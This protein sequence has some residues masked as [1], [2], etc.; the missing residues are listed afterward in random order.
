MLPTE[1]QARVRPS[2]MKSTAVVVVRGRWRGAEGSVDNM[3]ETRQRRRDATDEGNELSSILV[4]AEHE[5]NRS[6]DAEP[7]RKSRGTSAAQGRCAWCPL[8][9]VSSSW[10]LRSS[11]VG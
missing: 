10:V 5:G 6:R 11:M 2:N 1:W 9:G 4:F 8:A 3:P 7:S